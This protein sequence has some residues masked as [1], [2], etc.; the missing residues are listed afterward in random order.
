MFL[1]KLN[2]MKITK[3]CVNRG[4]VS[5]R[6]SVICRSFNIGFNNSQYNQYN[7]QSSIN[8]KNS[9]SIYNSS[10]HSRK[11]F[12]DLD[13]LKLDSIRAK[14]IGDS[15]NLMVTRERLRRGNIRG[16]EDNLEKLFLI[17]DK[18][19]MLNVVIPETLRYLMVLRKQRHHQSNILMNLCNKIFENF[20]GKDFPFFLVPYYLNHLTL[21]FSTKKIT[22]QLPSS[23]IGDL[24]T[25]F[26]EK[27]VLLDI[28]ELAFMTIYPQNFKAS[29]RFLPFLENNLLHKLDYL[30][31]SGDFSNIITIISNNYLL[32]CS[33]NF[34]KRFLSKV[35]DLINENLVNFDDLNNLVRALKRLYYKYPL[36]NN[37][38][39]NKILETFL[40]KIRDYL[41]E[42]PKD[43]I[44]FNVNLLNLMSFR[45]FRNCITKGE[46]N[47][48]NI[49]IKSI[50]SKPNM[51]LPKNLFAILKSASHYKE[52]DLPNT[53]VNKLSMIALSNIQNIQNSNDILSMIYF[54]SKINFDNK[55]K[56]YEILALK[57][58][59]VIIKG[60]SGG[61]NV[62]K[63]FSILKP[64]CE[65]F[66]SIYLSY[67]EEFNLSIQKS[68]EEAQ[69]N[70][71]SS[72]SDLE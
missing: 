40:W 56:L 67:L 61:K 10:F 69:N 5:K 32:T 12:T 45:I 15:G 8:Q 3:S 43:D 21:F 63:C 37:E 54:F 58:L 2:Y 44:I 48:G 13:M 26:F 60:D 30:E 11:N 33:N 64:K 70:E 22:K 19:E 35:G 59:D 27:A 18:Q 1:N 23:F 28:R 29:D 20:K 16:I 24:E 52:F 4:I 51:I 9:K 41:F 57:L 50:I 49:I 6:Y 42:I 31:K 39:V 71:D 36:A 14:Y 68:L 65:L 47:L 25:A 55:D 72:E 34:L 38:E 17:N 53:T 46:E 66:N 7:L 62:T